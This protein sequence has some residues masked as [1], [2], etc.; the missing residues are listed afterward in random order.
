MLTPKISFPAH[1]SKAMM[2]LDKIAICDR[3]V[4]RLDVSTN[5]F[6]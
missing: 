6:G 1:V 4:E 2:L 3:V 5:G